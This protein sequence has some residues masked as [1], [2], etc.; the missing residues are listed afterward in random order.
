MTKVKDW[1]E[2]QQGL[3]FCHCGCGQEIK[4]K[5][6]HFKNGTPKYICGHNK[7]KSIYFIPNQ[8]KKTTL[9]NWVTEEQNKHICQCGC[10]TV[11]KILPIHYKNGVPKCISGH[12]NKI[13]G[14]SPHFGCTGKRSHM[15]GRK[16]SEDT[17]RKMSLSRQGKNHP[18]WNGG[19]SFVPYCHKFNRKLKEQ[20]RERFGR[21]CVVCNKSESENGK[22]LSVHHVTYEKMDGCN[23]NDFKLVPLCASC[24][25]KTNFRRGNWEHSF[26]DILVQK[27]Q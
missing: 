12:H 17:K 3:H 20:T 26:N 27:I 10:G 6:Y 7:T 13:I 4:I 21:K 23:G 18:M 9:N 1:I 15:Y 24:H 14:K 5:P 11:I 19:S 16:L 8:Q 22:K 2:S 25:A